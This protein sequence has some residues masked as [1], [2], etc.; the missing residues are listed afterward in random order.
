MISVTQLRADMTFEIDGK[1]YVVLK[2]E[3]TKMGRGTA[4]IKVRARNLLTGTILEKSFIS[5]ARVEEINTVKR[6]LQ[7]LYQTGEEFTFMDPKTFEQIEMRGE[8]LGEQ[9]KFLS[10][11]IVV[12]VLFWPFDSTGSKE[13]IPLSVEL[14]PKME[15]TVTETG[16]G[17]KGDSATNIYKSATLSNGLVIKVP[18]FI[19]EGEKILVDTRN[20]EYMERVK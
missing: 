18:L 5:G 9:S 13:D 7:Y 3:H 16:P 10:E 8:I 1:P 20:G 11:G 4:T 2:Y 17:V 12:D 15:F 6:K 19:K 14:P